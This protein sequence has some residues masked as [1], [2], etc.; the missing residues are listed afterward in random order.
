MLRSPTPGSTCL[1]AP[2]TAPYWSPPG[3]RGTGDVALNSSV[4]LQG[5]STGCL[6][7]PSTEALE[8]LGHPVLARPLPEPDMGARLALA[9]LCPG[10]GPWGQGC[11]S[12]R[13]SCS[14]CPRAPSQ[15]G[16]RLKPVRGGSKSRRLRLQESRARFACTPATPSRLRPRRAAV[17]C[18]LLRGKGRGRGRESGGGASSPSSPAAS[19][20]PACPLS[21]GPIPTSEAWGSCRVAAGCQ[22]GVC[23]LEWICSGSL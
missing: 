6:C 4:T 16:R 12:L 19:S 9:G 3:D 15:E 22:A 18:D 11:P 10:A 17:G 5:P 8:P 1:P 2:L 20:V 21:P 14:T 23:A 13:G 7:F